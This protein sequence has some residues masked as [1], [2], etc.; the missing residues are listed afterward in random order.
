[1]VS[2]D[3]GIRPKPP[4]QGQKLYVYRDQYYEGQTVSTTRNVCQDPWAH[5]TP[6]Y[7]DCTGVTILGDLDEEN[8]EEEGGDGGRGEHGD[9]HRGHR[10]LEHLGD[11]RLMS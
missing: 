6:K 4:D 2:P 8:K 5:C 11:C 7:A 1:M 3:D 10:F 9:H